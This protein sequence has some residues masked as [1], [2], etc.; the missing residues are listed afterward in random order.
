MASRPL[1]GRKKVQEVTVLCTHP[2]SNFMRK[3][4]VLPEYTHAGN[5]LCNWK[6]KSSRLGRSA[7]FKNYRV[8]QKKWLG[9]RLISGTKK[10]S[11]KLFL[12]LKFGMQTKFYAKMGF[13][14]K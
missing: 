10:Q 9:F 4:I 7:I 11:Y 14:K 6:Y 8:C 2:G 1:A 13:S 3:I 12:F 5:R